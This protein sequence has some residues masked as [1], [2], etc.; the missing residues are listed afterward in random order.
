VV[1]PDAELFFK[2]T[3]LR[4]IDT[5]LMSQN[6]LLK[7]DFCL[8]TPMPTN[9]CGSFFFLVV[10]KALS[11]T[12]FFLFLLRE[13]Q[14]TLTLEPIDI[15]QDAWPHKF[16]GVYLIGVLMISFHN[17]S[18]WLCD[19]KCDDPGHAKKINK[20]HVGGPRGRWY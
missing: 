13:Y 18:N 9:N 3:V 14:D 11:T 8:E 12:I 17:R 4:F 19:W 5:Y 10:D 7:Y 1:R 2:A 16:Y 20:C 6:R 15:L